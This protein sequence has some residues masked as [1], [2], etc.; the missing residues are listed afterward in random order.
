[1]ETTPMSS[2][3]QKPKKTP[4]KKGPIRFE[5]I[6]PFAIVVGAVIAY[7]MLF[8]D[9]HLEWGIEWAGTQ[10]NGAQVD[11][12]DVDTSFWKAS[13]SIQGIQATNAQKPMENKVEIG[14]VRFDA[15]WDALLR[16]KFV[17]E[18][19]SILTIQVN[20]PRSSPGKVLPPDNKPDESLVGKMKDEAMQALRDRVEGTALGS[21]VAILE[22]F[23]PTKQIKDLGALK[24]TAKISELQKSL[25][26]KEKAWSQA[27]SAIPGEKNIQAIQT[28]IAGFK[29]SSNPIENAKQ[30]TQLND[31]IKEAQGIVNDV[32]S[33]GDGLVGDVNGFGKSVGSLD[34]LQKQDV[35]DLEKKFQL[36]SIDPASIGEQLFGKMILDKMSQVQ[37]YQ[38]LVK[39][40]MAQVPKSKNKEEKPA[41]PPR[42]KGKN[43][44]FGTQRSY[45]AFWL[46]KAAISSKAE[47]T[48][49]GGNVSGEI[50]DVTT[51][52]R[53][54]GRPITA[55]IEGDFPKP[56]VRDVK[57]NLLLDHTKEE[58]LDQIKVAVGS[59]PV[60]NMMLTESD[61]VKLGFTQASGAAEL[62]GTLAG[63]RVAIEAT[64][65]FRQAQYELAAKSKILEDIL[66]S[67][68]NNLSEVWVRAKMEGSW[69]DLKLAIDSNLAQA[70]FKGL[71]SQFDAKLGEARKKLNALIDEK[72]GKPKAELTQKFNGAKTKY[73]G[74]VEDRKKQAQA[75]VAQGQSKIDEVKKAVAKQG[76]GAVQQIK[77]KLPF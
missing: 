53:A 3:T 74:V 11:V 45:P 34:D 76:G 33:K 28:K 49:L 68:V 7:F 42:G 43:Y 47:N 30:V 56:Q 77:K 64:S 17:V 9:K 40:K 14:E 63:E 13:L 38:A 25:E 22:G 18:D 26:E 51:D 20:T 61:A 46:K 23:D 29:G 71:A 27:L 62:T 5:A 52:P 59:Y 6:V 16:A 4:K 72:V 69:E 66:R 21:L 75:V 54:L 48:P 35:R 37:K 36:P 60:S 73:T 67:T 8:F 15:L 58:S 2:T 1:M 44:S 10:L 55:K 32:N 24:T 57:I 65:R 19:A 12:D 50:R 39:Q 70:L 31:V 41:P